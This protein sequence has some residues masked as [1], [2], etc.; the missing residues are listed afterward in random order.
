MSLYEKIDKALKEAIKGRDKNALNALRGLRA[1]IKNKE[2]ELRRRLNENE[3][4][5]LIAKQIKQ[6]KESITEF[7]K[8]KRADLIE[9]ETKELEILEGF[10][11]SPLTEAELEQVL[12]EIIKEVGAIGHKDLGKVIKLAM[13]R[14]QGQIE[15][16]V[17]NEK[18]KHLLS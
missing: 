9:K 1:V 7:Q 3:I 8:A 11:P 2:V 15:G 13:S 14:L 6:R 4:I 16:K 5:Q 12:K 18:V 10:M 17:V